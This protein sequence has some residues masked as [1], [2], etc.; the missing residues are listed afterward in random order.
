MS[1][2]WG[3]GF[4]TH[5]L[6][7]QQ[8]LIFSTISE[9]SP[10]GARPGQWCPLEIFCRVYT[11]HPKLGVFFYFPNYSILVVV[12]SMHVKKLQQWSLYEVIEGFLL[13]VLNTKRP[14]SNI[15]L[16]GYK[17]FCIQIERQYQPRKD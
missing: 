2:I 5:F 14:L 12:I 8:N 15:W 16:L 7:N 9:N 13:F 17:Q 1:S 6:C 11:K 3:K 10:T 4:R